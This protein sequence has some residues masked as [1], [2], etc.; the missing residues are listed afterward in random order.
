MANPSEGGA[1]PSVPFPAPIDGARYM[2]ERGFVLVLL[3]PGTKVPRDPSWPTR[4]VNL[5]V[6]TISEGEF[7]FGYHPGASGHL[8]IDVDSGM[9]KGKQGKG[10]ESMAALVEKYGVIPQTFTVQ[11]PSGGLHLVFRLPPGAALLPNTAGKLGLNLDTRC[12]N[13]MVVAPGSTI[14]NG[15]YTIGD[16]RE[17]A[18]LPQWL[19]DLLS[20][21]KVAPLERPE[22]YLLDKPEHVEAVT[23]YLLDAP[24]CIEDEADTPGL[25]RIFCECRDL[26]VTQK[27]AEALVLEHYNPRCEPPWNLQDLADREHFHLKA[28]NAYRYAQNSAGAK[29]LEASTAAAVADFA[30]TPL[31]TIPTSEV[32]GNSHLPLPLLCAA[33]INSLAIKPRDWILKGYLLGSF[34]SITGAPGGTGKSNFEILKALS[35]AIGRSLLGE[36]CEVVKPG[37]VV[38]YNCEDPMEEM[39]RRMDA[40]RI[41]NGLSWQDMTRLHLVSGREH[42]LAV[43]MVNKA[44]EVTINTKAVETLCATVKSV[45][46]VLLSAD[47]MVRTHWLNENDNMAMD[48]VT[49]AFQRVSNATGCALSLVHHT[50]KAAMR[51]DSGD[52]SSQVGFRGAGSLVASA[53][54]GHLLTTMGPEEAKKMGVKPERRRWYFKVENAKANL[55]APAEY[56]DWFEA[57]GVE[58]PNGETVGV[59]RRIELGAARN[60]TS[61]SAVTEEKDSVEFAEPAVKAPQEKT[62][63]AGDFL[64]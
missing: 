5:E 24:P 3:Q 13:G 18:V 38:L 22:P 52:S 37:H 34:L 17:P 50:N 10:L 16:D 29:T 53:R 19:Y 33:S 11:T 31:P 48:K 32:N 57:A 2:A 58:I 64:E 28:R 4:M 47:P 49:Q 43:A 61:G 41:D 21:A 51:L 12:K 14:D 25:Y 23:Q 40:F 1:S 56:S 9:K 7:N 35:I 42:S 46:A 15:I 8:V 26:G 62:E 44:G 39:T 59:C 6:E 60:G 54:V 63:V 27:T 45:G 30:A 36:E 55:S 20:A